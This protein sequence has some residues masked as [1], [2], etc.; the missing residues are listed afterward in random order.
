MSGA[1]KVVQS[2]ENNGGFESGG[3]SIWGRHKKHMQ[4]EVSVLILPLSDSLTLS[5]LDNCPLDSQSSCSGIQESFYKSRSLPASQALPSLHAPWAACFVAASRVWCFA[6][7][8]N[9]AEEELP[10]MLSVFATQS[11]S[12]E[13]R[14]DD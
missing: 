8:R 5:T 12:I 2:L 14:L 6:G 11:G 1:L 7:A 4:Q 3:F 13:H 9:P 10:C